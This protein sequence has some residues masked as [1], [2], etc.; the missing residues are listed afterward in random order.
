MELATGTTDFFSQSFAVLAGVHIGIGH[1][2]QKTSLVTCC[3][4][5]G[6]V[7]AAVSYS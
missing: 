5:V 2:V 1:L 4:P 7:T 6:A 3:L